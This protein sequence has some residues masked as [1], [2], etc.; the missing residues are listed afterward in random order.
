MKAKRRQ[1]KDVNGLEHYR[2]S[3]IKS[4]G[5]YKIFS[6]IAWALIR[7]GRLFQISKNVLNRKIKKAIDILEEIK[8]KKQGAAA[9]GHTA[10]KHQKWIFF[11]TFIY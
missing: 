7:G 3:S 2:I 9:H 8:K 5:A 4:P 1:T 6:K 10:V 11:V